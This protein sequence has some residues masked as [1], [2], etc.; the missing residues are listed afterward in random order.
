MNQF[1][2]RFL[3]D[4]VERHLATCA[5]GNVVFAITQAGAE[6]FGDA[7]AGRL[8]GERRARLVRLAD[9][10][11]EDDPDDVGA[12]VLIAGSQPDARSAYR[13]MERFKDRGI[14]VV[15]LLPERRP[16]LR[17]PS[18]E[19]IGVTQPGM[20]RLAAA[21]ARTIRPRMGSYCEFGVYDGH[22]FTAAGHALRDV[23][24]Q[25]VA[26]DSYRGIGGTTAEESDHFPDGAYS[27]NVQTLHY[28]LRYSGLADLPVKVVAGFYEDTL[29]GRTAADDGI[30]PI[31]V[32]HV[33]VDVYEPALLA[34]RYVADGLSDGALLLFDDFD[35]IAARDDVGER[36]A[37]REWLDERPDVY[38][39][40]YRSYATFGRSFIVHRRR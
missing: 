9:L 40:P 5:G 20:F 21:Y 8:D 25:F 7:L 17:P 27:A 23:C 6:R 14:P 2:T 3:E 37:L 11:D 1:E 26:F 38:V 33:D 29:R 15:T 18:W 12:I 30:G 4:A 31:S 36:R 22:S 19:G 13:R 24:G 35:Q 32:V 10:L 16:T 34:L 39:D 28:N